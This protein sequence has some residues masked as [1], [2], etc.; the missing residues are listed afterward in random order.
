MLVACPRHGVICDFLWVAGVE[1]GFGVKECSLL[2][3]MQFKS[4]TDTL[5]EFELYLLPPANTV[6]MSVELNYLTF[7]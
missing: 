2:F 7:N 4:Y 3:V 5:F 6:V 1:Q